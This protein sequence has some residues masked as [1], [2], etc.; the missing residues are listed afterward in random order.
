[1][2]EIIVPG[3][4]EPPTAVGRTPQGNGLLK[5][6]LADD[7]HFAPA[8]R[9]AGTPGDRRD[10][11]VFRL[12]VDGVQGV[13][14][15]AVD[16]ELID[17]IAGVGNEELAD[18][19]AVGAVEVQGMPPT[20]FV[21]LAGIGLGVAARVVAHGTKVVVNYVQQHSQA[22]GVGLVDEEAEVVRHAVKP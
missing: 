10:D 14:P 9:L 16:M 8:G 4:I 12:V 17:P 6:V 22:M 11:M 3:R 21:I 15:Q 2:V 13:Q 7:Q 20:G 1:M 5:L 19:S 18:R